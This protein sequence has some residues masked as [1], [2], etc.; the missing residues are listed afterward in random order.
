[1][2]SSPYSDRNWSKDIERDLL[3]NAQ[4]VLC[5]ETPELIG[6]WQQTS[7]VGDWVCFAK[8]LGVA[9]ASAGTTT[10]ACIGSAYDA[11]R[12]ALDHQ[13]IV[14]GL[15][16]SI[17]EFEDVMPATATLG[18]SWLLVVAI[19]H[20]LRIY[21]DT[22]G[23]RGAVFHPGD[24]QRP[25]MIASQPRLLAE[26]RGLERDQRL[27]AAIQPRGANSWPFAL[28]PYSAV[29]RLLPNTCLDLHSGEVRRF[30]PVESPPRVGLEEAAQSIF[31]LISG[32][33]RAA[34]RSHKL[35]LGLSAGYDSRVAL[36]CM[37]A[38]GQQNFRLCN[39]RRRSQPDCDRDIPR[40]LAR[41]LE[42]DLCTVELVK[43]RDF[44]QMLKLLERNCADMG[45]CG[46][47]PMT[48]HTH[49]DADDIFVLGQG[50]ASAKASYYKALNANHKLSLVA[51]Y[52]LRAIRIYGPG[53]RIAMR[54]LRRWFATLPAKC[55]VDRRA[56]IV[57]EG[58]Y[59]TWLSNKYQVMNTTTPTLSIFNC[60]QVQ[61]LALGTAIE[62]RRKPHSLMRRICAKGLPGLADVPFNEL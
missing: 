19:G 54:E 25:L 37:L 58:R 24:S 33:L 38:Q 21:P 29:R 61:C 6:H 32:L 36:A 31:D 15:A 11:A 44:Q 47:I 53:H 59:G 51:W 3:Y 17:G 40:R 39:Q 16:E 9:R 45:S 62:H 20:D 35:Q 18:G 7:I 12:P 50:A 60:R 14:R 48:L 42:L 46:S 23:L 57:W 34:A 56:L 43:R 8:N 13:Q 55:P 28:T 26:V 4:F 49:V 22:L 30:W 41:L 27:V 1:M 2:I 52:Q 5:R 10:V